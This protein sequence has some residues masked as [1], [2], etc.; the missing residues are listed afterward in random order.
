MSSNWLEYFQKGARDEEIASVREALLSKGWRLPR[1]GRFAVL[2]V[3]EAVERCKDAL[4]I[5]VRFINLQELQDPSHTGI[6]G[7]ASDALEAARVLAATVSP[8]EVYPAT[9]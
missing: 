4:D 1:S 5:Q 2:S 6:F 8:T 7:L 9:P 3:G